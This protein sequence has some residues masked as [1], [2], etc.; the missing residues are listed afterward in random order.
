MTE[1]E[2]LKELEGYASTAVANAVATYPEDKELCL[3]LY[4]PWAVNWYTDQSARC[5]FPEL[6]GRAGLAVTCA[7]GPRDPRFDRLD[8]TDVLRAIAKAGG[9]VILAIRQD[10]PRELKRKNGLA[11]GSL[12]AAFKAA[13]AVGAL[14]DGPSRDIEAIRALGFQYLL[15]G[16]C[17]GRGDF[18]LKA[19]NVPVSICGMDISPGEV[20][21]MD[22]NGAVKFPRE[23]LPQVL[24]RVR[25]LRAGEQDAMGR[26]GAASGDVERV[27]RVMKGLE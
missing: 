14:S 4:D 2:M 12:T 18:S 10:L 11:G 21:H 13:G 16:V 24:D 5:V 15:T 1:A 22:A 8:W 19:V 6:G 3:G 23:A 17:A 7:V 27:I 20:I 25:R 26:I 9:P